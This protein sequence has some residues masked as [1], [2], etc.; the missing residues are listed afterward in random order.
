MKKQNAP[1]VYYPPKDKRLEQFAFKVVK[2]LDETFED[3]FSNSTDAKDFTRFLK[4]IARMTAK[5][6]NS[7]EKR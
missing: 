5:Q 1:I 6:L 3:E 2:S 4:I 7:A